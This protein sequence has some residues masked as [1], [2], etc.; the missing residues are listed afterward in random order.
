ME[1]VVEVSTTRPRE[2]QSSPAVVPSTPSLQPH[3]CSPN[4]S[5]SIIT[6]SVVPKSPF[7]SRFMNSTPLASP[8]KKAIGYLEEVG[9]FTKFDPQEDW[10]P[11]T[12]SRNG[13][14]YYAAFHMLSSGMGF[15]ALVLP[16]AFTT[17]G[18]WVLIYVSLCLIKCTV[19][20]VGWMVGYPNLIL[21]SSKIILLKIL[22]SIWFENRFLF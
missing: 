16:L 8:M 1:E 14:A 15:Q 17:L 4:N 12:E 10:L 6:E 20:M 5:M 19:C 18:W 11:I 22:G 3:Y 21:S 13:N 9:R 7:A 2:T